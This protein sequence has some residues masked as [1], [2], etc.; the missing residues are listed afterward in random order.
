MVLDGKQRVPVCWWGYEVNGSHALSC[1]PHSTN[2]RPT[3]DTL[4]SLPKFE[5]EQNTTAFSISTLN[6]VYI[7]AQNLGKL[8]KPCMMRIL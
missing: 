8:F 5:L 7:P 2:R 4:I 1:K 6:N 3:R